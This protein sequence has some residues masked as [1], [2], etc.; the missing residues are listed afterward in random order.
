MGELQ[1]QFAVVVIRSED[2]LAIVASSDD[3]VEPSLDFES[4]LAHS[5]SRLLSQHRYV[6]CE[7]HFCTP[8]PS[9]NDARHPERRMGRVK[10]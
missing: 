1:E 2:E 10:R 4:R 3:V 8:D 9:P 7:L 6:K 5:S